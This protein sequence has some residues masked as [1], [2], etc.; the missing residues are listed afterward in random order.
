VA[1]YSTLLIGGFDSKS[2][3]GDIYDTVEIVT[4]TGICVDSLPPLPFA[5]S[6]MAVS[7]YNTEDLLVCG[8]ENRGPGSTNYHACYFFLQ[9]QGRWVEGPSTIYGRD[10]AHA[11]AI[12]GPDSSVLL[13]GGVQ[14]DSGETSVEYLRFGF[15]AKWE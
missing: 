10:L 6:G 3:E 8:G 12:Q 4:E 7:H 11:H 13:F 5:K 2:A 14:G 9:S 15:S 1:Q